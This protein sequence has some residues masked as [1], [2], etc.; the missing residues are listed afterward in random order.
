MSAPLVWVVGASG[1]LG[2]SVVRGLGGLAWRPE[3]PIGWGDDSRLERDFR[4]AVAAF[5]TCTLSEGA[6]AWA[7]CWCAGAG[8]VGT[9]AAALTAETKAFRLFLELL[10]TESRLMAIPGYVVLAS[11]AGGVY[12][13]SLVCPI[14]EST[15][16]HPISD[17]GRTKLEQ[18]RMLCSWASRRSPAVGILVARFANLYGTGQ[19]LDKPQGLISHLSRCLIFNTPV[20]V[21][22]SLDTIRD[23]LFAEDA[24]RQLVAGLRRLARES[25]GEHVQVTKIYASEREISIAGLLGIFRRISRRRLRVI[26]GLHPGSA[27]QPR[28]LQFR[29]R[30]WRTLDDDGGRQ[31]ELVEGINQVYRDQLALF[32]R[33]LLPPPSHPRATAF[34]STYS[35]C[36]R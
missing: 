25:R 4:E 17:Y 5:A 33:G 29:S 18:E 15:D 11:S 36:K 13:G 32:R 22:V 8:V 27:L 20:H 26:C 21:Y 16:P 30:V 24:G 31:V 28:R 1:L 9:S 23:Y 10:S 19:H 12:G 2:A 35:A 3:R 14:T 7:I 6:G 34:A